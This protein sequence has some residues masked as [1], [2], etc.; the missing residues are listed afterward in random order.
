MTELPLKDDLSDQAIKFVRMQS[1]EDLITELIHVKN[2][3]DDYYQ[4]INPLKIIYMLGQKNGS[5]SLSL[6]EWI[7]PRICETQEFQVYPSDVV[8]MGQCTNE[9]T[10]YYYE[11]LFKFAQSKDEIDLHKIMESK[12]KKIHVKTEESDDNNPTDE[13]VEYI[14]KVLDD[15]TKTKRILH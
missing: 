1:G 7:F 3:K 11:A 14:K 10:D 12:T 2:E 6:V 15:L 13:E 5:V 8:T 4:F 9:L